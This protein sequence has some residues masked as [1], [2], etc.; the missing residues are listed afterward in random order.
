ME[1]YSQSVEIVA[2]LMEYPP[3][4]SLSD[5]QDMRLTQAKALVK[6]EQVH[7]LEDRK[8]TRL[9]SSH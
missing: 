1:P 7:L 5:T 9:N 3:Y 4:H 2:A 8:S 6:A